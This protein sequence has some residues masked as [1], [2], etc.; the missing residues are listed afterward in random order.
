MRD[1]LTPGEWRLLALLI[2][3]IAVVALFANPPR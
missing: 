3:A 1:A 2:V